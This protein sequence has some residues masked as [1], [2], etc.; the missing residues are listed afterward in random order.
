MVDDRVVDGQLAGHH[1]LQVG[2]DVQQLGVESLQ[3]VHLVGDALGQRAH[4]GVFDVSV[5][6]HGEPSDEDTCCCLLHSEGSANR[7]T[8]RCSGASYFYALRYIINRLS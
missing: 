5:E 2:P 4:R 3:A 6:T 1:S 8:T 7:Q